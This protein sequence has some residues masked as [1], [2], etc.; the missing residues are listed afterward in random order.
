MRI[1][2]ASEFFILG[3]DDLELKTAELALLKKHPMGGIIL[4]KRNISSLEQV[5]ALNAA[6]INESINPPLLSVDQEGGR[7]ARLRGLC[8]DI[9]PMLE[10]EP[11]FLKN[12][13]LAYRLGAMQGRELALLG[14]NLNF[15]PVCDVFINKDNEVIGDR[16]FSTEAKVVAQMACEFISGLQG[17]GVAACAKHFPGHGQ[18]SV[19]SHFAL[20][21]QRASLDEL[22][23]CELIPFISAIKADVA[24]IMTAH[25]VN[26]ALDPVPATMSKKTLDGILRKKLGFQNVLIS[27]D[28]EM[29]AVADNYN[30]ADIIEKSFRASVDMFIMGH[31]LAKNQEAIGILQHLIDTDEEI[32]ALSIKSAQRIDQLRKRY[33]G[34]PSPPDISMAQ[35]VIRSSPHLELLSM[36]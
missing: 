3:I 13:K 21:V 34:K 36:A 4:F 6:I 23:N 15:S 10:L 22:S 35:K 12:P 31:D 26:E 8:T 24:T 28:L 20:P 30:L 5:I 27:D 32:K 16:A 7:V 1:P 18:T 17:S 29:K 19:D 2:K 14:F 9:P 33:Q 25:I 11:L